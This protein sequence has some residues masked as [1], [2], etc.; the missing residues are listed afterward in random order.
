[1]C[2]DNASLISAGWAPLCPWGSWTEFCVRLP[3]SLGGWL[4]LL[5]FLP[6]CMRVICCIGCLSI[7][8][9][10][11]SYRCAVLSLCLSLCPLLLLWPAVHCR[12]RKH[13]GWC[14]L[15]RGRS[16]WSYGLIC[17]ERGLF[18]CGLISIECSLIWDV[19]LAVVYQ[20]K[21]YMS[22]TYFYFGSGWER[23]R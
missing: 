13:V 17:S 2:P 12:I 5:L 18:S 16:F 7:R 4:S 15:L 9:D 10:I 22:L 3:D 21:F 11:V 1:M 23:L 19:L 20:A 8:A 6:A 14:I